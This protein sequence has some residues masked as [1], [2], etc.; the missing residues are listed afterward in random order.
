MTARLN[1]QTLP[2]GWVWSTLSKLCRINYRN[3]ELRNLPDNLEVTFLPM[4]AV[5]AITGTIAQPEI[6]K[7]GTV[8]KGFTPFENNDVLFA[9]ITPSME[10][11]KATIATDLVNGVGFGS[12]EFHVLSPKEHISPK[13]IFY[14]IRQSSF[15]A[16]AKANFSGTAGQLRV[17]TDFLTDYPIPHPPPNE[18]HR[19]VEAIETQFT[20]LDA[21]VTALK[22]SQAN[23]KRYR[24]AVLKAACEGRLVPTEAAL[25]QAEGR[26][27]E[28][29]SVLLERILA[30][31]RLKWEVEN[32]K[33]KY[34][35]PVAPDMSELSELPEGWCWASLDIIAQ[36]R[37]GVA[38]GRK[39]N[40]QYVVSLPY[41]RVANVQDGY[42]DLSEIKTIEILTNEIERY[43]LKPYDIL[44]NEGGDRDKLGRG[45]IWLG[46]I[47][48]CIHQNHV[49]A[50]R[51]YTSAVDPKWVNFV[52]QL[53][54]ARDHFWKQA[55]QTTNLASINSTNLRSLPVPIPPLS[56]QVRIITE[57]ER[58]ISLIDNLEK[59]ITTD[60]ARANRLRQ[61]ILKRAFAGQLVPQDPNDEPA[62]VLLE[63]IQAAKNGEPV[64]VKL[65]L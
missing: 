17:P 7:L 58:R 1:G 47:K 53:T 43:R 46:D 34:Q 28:P 39:F 64:Q 40:N 5:D 23:L 63:R 48:D 4:A 15:R 24:A 45:A 12:T 61:S 42:L 26:P 50:A 21:A 44:F 35:E 31:R 38:K 56:E 27:Y 54:Y 25:A 62:S 41:L 20:R 57:V 18:Q 36:V 8:R 11:G 49:F 6:R 60:L 32:P 9:K 52:R 22:R 37:T 30:E 59:T 16:D 29:A 65:P 13:W 51:L 10:N 19:I 14:Y 3:P 55:S 2:E 33:K